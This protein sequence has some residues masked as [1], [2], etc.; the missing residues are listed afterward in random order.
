METVTITIDGQEVKT[1]V[2]MTVLEAAL[3]AGIYIPN[4]CYDPDLKPYAGCRLCIVE[5]DGMRGLPASCT[6][7][8]AQGM[9]VRTETPQVDKARRTALELLIADHAGDCLV[10]PR[11]QTCGLQRAAAHL[12]VTELRFP[13]TTRVIPPDASNPFFTR[14][15]DKCVLCAKCVRTCD[16]VVNTRAI[17]LAF[18]GYASIVT[19]L[20]G[21][22]L[23][24]SNCISCGECLVRCPT[25]A[26]Q[27]K[28]TLPPTREVKT[29]CPY[30]GVGCSLYLGVRGNRVVAVRGDREGPNQG[31]L[32]VKGRFGMDFIQD[33]HR[34][35]K[36]LIRRHGKLTEASWDEALD[37]VAARF[38]SHK[39]DAFAAISSAKA[40]NEDNYVIQKFTRAVMGTNNLDH[41]ARL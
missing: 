9:L 16:E 37:L 24:E 29:I 20:A 17:D 21:K 3:A 18:R 33:E 10:C 4:L 14:D 26:L 40:T 13:K 34:L 39:G 23:I 25:A 7:T 36:P 5:I 2:G 41:C 31:L 32:C 12:G 15:L 35:T 1:R 30:C 19:T 11:N 38:A 8:V 22:P 6:V 28:Q 27:L